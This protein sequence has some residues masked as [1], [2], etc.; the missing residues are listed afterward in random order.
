MKRLALAVL[1]PAILLLAGF[2]G[3][4]DPYTACVQGSSVAAQSI[5]QGMTTV[6][7]LRQQGTL[8]VAEESQALDYM[9][10]AN[11]ADGA[12]LSCAQE[13]HTNGNKPGTY[14]ACA[15]TFNTALN[16]PAELAL[17]HV[18]NAQASQT[19]NTIVIGVT[20]GVNSLVAALGGA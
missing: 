11:K 8:S 20:A 3:C 6:D 19:L 16:N 1:L 2:K 7:T 14:T 10:F 9:E 5:N 4:N 17:L 13:A 15:N 18:S 12:F